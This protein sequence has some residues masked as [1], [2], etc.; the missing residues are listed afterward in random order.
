MVNE[1]FINSAD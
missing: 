1:W